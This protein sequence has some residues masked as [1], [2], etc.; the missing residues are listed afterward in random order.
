M[1]PRNLLR[2]F[3][4]V[5]CLFPASLTAQ[6]LIQD[7]GFSGQ[8]FFSY[9]RTF[10]NDDTNV[11]NEF[12]LKRGYITFR[13]NISD[14]VSI[15]FTQ[16]VS[17]DQEGDGI[18]NIELRLKYALVNVKMND[19]GFF[20][21]Q[22]VE[23]G[24]VNRPWIDFEQDIND[25]RSQSAMFLDNNNYLSSA[26]YGITY[27]ARL[28]EELP[29]ESQTGL[30]SAP[31]RYGSLSFGVYNGGGYSSLEYN[32][33]KLLEG[34]LSLRWFPD[35]VPGFQ[36]TFFG[37]LGKGNLPESP[38]FRMAGSA[39]SYES[40]YWIGVVQGFT[41][42]GDG[43]G[44]KVTAS[45]EG[46]PTHGWSVFQ[47][48]KPF[49]VPLSLTLRF[50]E[51]INRDTSSWFFREAIGGVA[52]RFPNRSKII[53]NVD[54]RWFQEGNDSDHFTTVEIITEVRF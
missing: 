13:N 20:K 43:S 21:K 6:S 18:G 5:L 44:R 11:D 52:Y 12:L 2:V 26:D 37:A 27:S 14:R 28:G 38:D 4:P 19:T 24:V 15:R 51:L 40:P 36:T 17:L 49:I 41:G 22:N 16:D 47:E 10:D 42:V 50:D 54:R 45:L 48:L 30:G 34:R 9:E 31:G 25:Y 1:N 32:K 8:F 39:L 53:L 35:R 7:L 33:N 23:F 46:L 3:L 29:E